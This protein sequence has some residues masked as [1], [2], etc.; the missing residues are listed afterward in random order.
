M[1]KV[2]VLLMKFFFVY[3]KFLVEQ[4]LKMFQMYLF[5]SNKLNLISTIERQFLNFANI[6]LK[7][8]MYPKII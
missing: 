7:R 3:P 8:K 2:L 1:K 4:V 5:P 6:F